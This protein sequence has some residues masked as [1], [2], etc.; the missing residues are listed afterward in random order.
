ML[1]ALLLLGRQDSKLFETPLLTFVRISKETTVDIS[2]GKPLWQAD[3][4]PFA[5]RELP[6]INNRS[7]NAQVEWTLKGAKFQIVCPTNQDPFRAGSVYGF[8]DERL[9]EAD[10]ADNKL[11]ACRY[12]CILSKDEKV[13]SWFRAMDKRSPDPKAANELAR[14][15]GIDKEFSGARFDPE[16]RE[17]RF[18]FDGQKS[19]RLGNVET[20]PWIGRLRVRERIGW[21]SA[22]FIEQREEE[23]N[24]PAEQFWNSSLLTDLP[25][26][27][28]DA[29]NAAMEAISHRDSKPRR[30]SKR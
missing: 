30:G 16:A 26:A 17:Y 4:F 29:G 3:D 27:W 25:L 6:A 14:Y 19:G 8:T 12:G 2:T 21:I 13:V 20:A 24:G 7:S 15:W 9:D 5:R 11:G 1:V 28:Q 23:A 22:C 18:K 10:S